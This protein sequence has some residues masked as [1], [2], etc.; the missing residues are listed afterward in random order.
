MKKPKCKTKAWTFTNCCEKQRGP[1]S[2]LAIMA[3]CFSS[4]KD[5]FNISRGKNLYSFG[6][7]GFMVQKRFFNKT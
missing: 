3:Q 1:L 2:I 5:F 7:I 6:I 4:P